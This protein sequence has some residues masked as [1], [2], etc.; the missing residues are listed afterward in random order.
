MTDPME[1]K[2][3]GNS[4]DGPADIFEVINQSSSEPTQPKFE[5]G[6][7]QRSSEAS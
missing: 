2:M 3:N 1:E 4:V 5:P 6:E 7:S